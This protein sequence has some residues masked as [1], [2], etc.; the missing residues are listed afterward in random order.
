MRQRRR[1]ECEVAVRVVGAVVVIVPDGEVL[2]G[3]Q[4]P[5]QRGEA[6][7]GGP[8]LVHACG[9]LV[10]RLE[11]AVAVVDVVAEP[12]HDVGSLCGDGI[13]DLEAG[14]EGVRRELV[15]RVGDVIARG[16]GDEQLARRGRVRGCGGEGGRL[17]EL[18]RGAVDQHAVGVA[19]VGLQAGEFDARG[20][21]GLGAGGDRHTALHSVGLRVRPVLELNLRGVVGHQPHADALGRRRPRH[22]AAG[23]GGRAGGGCV[24]RQQQPGQR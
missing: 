6:A 3:A 7:C 1:L 14:A 17:V 11:V 22:R 21:A 2:A 18:D 24:Q 15:R 12:Q 23:Q 5:L 4:Q 9:G 8:A 16:G 10:R 19:R 20:V 13:E